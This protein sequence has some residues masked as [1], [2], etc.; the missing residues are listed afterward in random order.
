M[1]WT[2]PAHGLHKIGVTANPVQR[3]ASV[4]HDVLSKLNY[5]GI[6]PVDDVFKVESKIHRQFAR[7]NVPHP[8]HAIG[9]EWFNSLSSLDL[10][11]V[12]SQ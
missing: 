8:N 11:K 6:T 3:L 9:T 7:K 12:L 1:S 10:A 5:V 2:T 4:Q